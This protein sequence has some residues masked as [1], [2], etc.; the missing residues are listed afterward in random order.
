MTTVGTTRDKGQGTKQVDN[1]QQSREV[2]VG[3]GPLPVLKLLLMY[4]MVIIQAGQ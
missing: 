4:S 2:S 1:A 3:L